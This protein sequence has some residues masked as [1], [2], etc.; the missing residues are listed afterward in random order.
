MRSCWIGLVTSLSSKFCVHL[1]SHVFGRD[2]YLLLSLK[3]ATLL[4]ASLP[5]VLQSI[6]DLAQKAWDG[7]DAVFW[8]S[9]DELVCVNLPIACRESFRFSVRGHT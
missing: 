7:N 2:P 4:N 5:T 9:K 6:G 1:F 8:K 3:V